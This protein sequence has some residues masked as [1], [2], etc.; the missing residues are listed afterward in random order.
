MSVSRREE[1]EPILVI[2]KEFLVSSFALQTKAASIWHKL[3]ILF[4]QKI[5]CV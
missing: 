1:L 2:E 5:V 4:E 3:Q